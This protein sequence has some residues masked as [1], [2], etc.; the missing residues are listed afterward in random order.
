MA[1]Y[2][3]MDSP[4]YTMVRTKISEARNLAP[5]DIGNTSDPYYVLFTPHDKKRKSKVVDRTL[6]PK[7]ANRK[8]ST[9][10]EIC[11]RWLTDDILTILSK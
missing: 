10:S 4:N 8:H 11:I 1:S 3:S 6:N 9:L 5:K 2:Q 7:Y